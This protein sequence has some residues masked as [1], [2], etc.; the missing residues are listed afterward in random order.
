MSRSL[1]GLLAIGLVLAGAAF[2][3]LEHARGPSVVERGSVPLAPAP[4][5]NELQ[6]DVEPRAYERAL[7]SRSPL[8][9]HGLDLPY[10]PELVLLCYDANARRPL[11]GAVVHV[12]EAPEDPRFVADE[13]GRV[14][15]E[16]PPS[17]LSVHAVHGELEADAT[18]DEWTRSPV[19]LTLAR[20]V[21][22]TI[23]IVTRDEHGALVAGVPVQVVDEDYADLVLWRGRTDSTG[24]AT[25]DVFGG[26]VVAALPL[27]PPIE[28]AVARAS[29]RMEPVV[30]V[31]P[32]FTE[33]E[34]VLVGADGDVLPVWDELTVALPETASSRLHAI[35][36][37]R[38]LTLELENGRA[39]LAWPDGLA[40]CALS[41]AHFADEW[42]VDA[43]G[44][45]PAPIELRLA[46]ETSTCFA[47]VD[48]AGR[49]VADRTLGWTVRSPGAWFP[50]LAYEVRTDAE[51]RCVLGCV[52]DAGERFVLG[53]LEADPLRLGELAARVDGGPREH[54]PRVRL[55]PAELAL[56]GRVVDTLGAS[57]AYA[58][59]ETK[60]RFDNAA[61][62]FAT[63]R[64]DALGRFTLRGP[65]VEGALEVRVRRED[66]AFRFEGAE[67][68]EVKTFAF[69]ARDVVLTVEATG[70]LEGELWVDPKVDCANL[71]AYGYDGE[72]W[73]DAVDF[74]PDGERVRFRVRNALPGTY[75]LHFLHCREYGCG[76]GVIAPYDLAA[77]VSNVRIEAGV[78][79]RDPR[80]DALDLRGKLRHPEPVDGP[81][82]TLRVV[83]AEGRS[84]AS[85]WLGFRN[86]GSSSHAFWSEGR[87]VVPR[88]TAELAV[89]SPG[90]DVLALPLP[91]EDGVCVLTPLRA[92]RVELA[93]PD[94]W[95]RRQLDFTLSI[96][97]QRESWM[98]EFQS[99]DTPAL[100]TALDEA[101][102]ATLELPAGTRYVAQVSVG[103]GAGEGEA[104]VLHAFEFELVQGGA[105]VVRL[106]VDED[107]LERDLRE[108][109][110][111]LDD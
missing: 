6:L 30:L 76:G 40:R 110:A 61:N 29:E 21:L 43:P 48:E 105:P 89:W 84:I 55:A 12:D 14:N 53:D 46:T 108:A 106:Q 72:R 81:Q 99:S 50:R 58:D 91:H 49:P 18:I 59:L 41:C 4:S 31:V 85:G 79:T 102:G 19:V 35:G 26:R 101:H 83:D 82:H 3:L 47:V 9:A 94:R 93:L 8:A 20:P 80:L 22:P 77:S 36:E 69:G 100:E 45:S 64:T 66:E 75:T 67:W 17:P 38:T 88:G 62:D 7:D 65:R 51:G 2:L 27:S 16:R 23:E 95:A 103:W 73:V 32:R 60:V 104:L 33:H 90:H 74:W 71:D 37:V 39:R 111:P 24:R 96:E 44:S 42:T 28:Q 97:P 54:F 86:A 87:C 56:T 25:A 57:L 68:S 109:G 70:G 15:L 13:H 34:L 1:L 78:V 63:M 11:P 52:L 92:T 107:A 98:Y 5:S 10:G